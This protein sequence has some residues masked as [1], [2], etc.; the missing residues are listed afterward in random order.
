MAQ[1]RTPE[2]VVQLPPGTAITVLGDLN[3]VGGTQPLDTLL[4]GDIQ[5]NARYGPDSLPVVMDFISVPDP[6]RALGACVVGLTIARALLTTI[7]PGS[8]GQSSWPG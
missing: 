3:L 5:D 7:H 1:A 2:G 6:A 8:P 4:T